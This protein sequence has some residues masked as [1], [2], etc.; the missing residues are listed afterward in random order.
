MSDEPRDLQQLVPDALLADLPDPRE[1]GRI[2]KE[3]V[4][5]AYAEFFRLR[6]EVEQAED[7]FDL[8]RRLQ[9]AH[10]KLSDYSRAF[11]DAAVVVRQLQQEELVEAVGEQDGIPT[12]GLTIPTAGGDIVV[13]PD[14]TNDNVIDADQVRTVIAAQAARNIMHVDL[15]LVEDVETT[16]AELLDEAFGHLLACGKWEPQIT[17]VK[18]TADAFS[19][20][21]DD[22][23]AGVLRAT[24]T[25]RR[26]Y[27][28]RVKV[29]RKN[30]K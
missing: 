29:E 26:V 9:D 27:H 24:I 3:R 10:E 25:K 8:Q 30:P 28:D 12:S 11:K 15:A 20:A 6:G 2:V 22:P 19:R 13:K 23:M 1:L 17:K 5:L 21:G 18:A 7:T 4:Q 14:V 16:L